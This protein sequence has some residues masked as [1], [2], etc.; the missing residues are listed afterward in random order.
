MGLEEVQF[1]DLTHQ[2][3]NHYTRVLDETKK[4]VSDLKDTVSQEYIERMQ[5]GLGHW[6]DGGNKGYLA[7]GVFHFQKA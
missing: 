7:W 5:K 1:E 4:K 2:L 6:I 3:V